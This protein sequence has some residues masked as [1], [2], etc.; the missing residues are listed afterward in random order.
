MSRRAARPRVAPQSGNGRRDGRLGTAARPPRLGFGIQRFCLPWARQRG[1]TIT[2]GPVAGRARSSRPYASLLNITSQKRGLVLG[3]ESASAASRYVSQGL[4]S[5]SMYDPRSR[6]TCAFRVSEGLKLALRLKLDQLEDDVTVAFAWAVEG[7][8]GLSARRTKR[9]QGPCCGRVPRGAR[10][11]LLSAATTAAQAA[12]RFR[13][14]HALGH[15]V[16]VDVGLMPASFA[17]CDD[18]ADAV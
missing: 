3:W 18:G 13:D 1:A 5:P 6:E 12:P 16:D 7:A 8:A 11:D 9:G 2:R 17:C 4:S 15:G 10:I 14:R